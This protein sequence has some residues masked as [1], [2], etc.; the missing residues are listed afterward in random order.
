MGSMIA[1]G[2]LLT[3]LAESYSLKSHFTLCSA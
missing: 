2:S 1:G 3:A